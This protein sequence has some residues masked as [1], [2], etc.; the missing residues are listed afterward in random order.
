MLKIPASPKD[1]GIEAE[2]VSAQKW[3]S[4]ELSP[5]ESLVDGSY[6]AHHSPANKSTKDR[7]AI[8]AIMI[9]SAK[10]YDP[11]PTWA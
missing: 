9:S 7:K 8:Y 6:L 10:E 3:V 4:R 11:P 5:G 1:N 2:W